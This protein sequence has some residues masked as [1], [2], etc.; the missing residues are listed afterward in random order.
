MELVKKVWVLLMGT[1][2]GSSLFLTG[3]N[4]THYSYIHLLSGWTLIIRHGWRA[5]AA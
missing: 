5:R 2:A 4:G 3:L 1:V